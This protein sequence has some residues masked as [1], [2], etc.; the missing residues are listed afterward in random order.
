MQLRQNQ[1][2]NN[3]EKLRV[4][5]LLE[6]RSSFCCES[7]SPGAATVQ[8]AWGHCS[9]HAEKTS[10]CLQVLHRRVAA[11][12]SCFEASLFSSNQKRNRSLEQNTFL[13]LFCPTHRNRKQQWKGKPV[14]SN[15][16]VVKQAT[17]TNLS[18]EL[19]IC[20]F[21]D[22]RQGQAV[23]YK[24][25]AWSKQQQSSMGEDAAMF[26]VCLITCSSSSADSLD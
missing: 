6:R 2:L 13:V 8:E 12:Q 14:R 18:T 15:K 19:I 5:V 11:T 21:Q 1:V 3:G 23:V 20:R 17:L 10:V 7:F 16:R 9:L 22:V 26:L 4:E 25:V 24:R